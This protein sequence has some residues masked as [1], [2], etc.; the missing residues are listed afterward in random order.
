MN[1]M[2]DVLLYVN[3]VC[4][5]CQKVSLIIGRK[6]LNWREIREMFTENN[7]NMHMLSNRYTNSGHPSQQI[8]HLPTTLSP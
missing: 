4:L 8:R 6:A 3:I 5:L 2:L 7:T 1:E